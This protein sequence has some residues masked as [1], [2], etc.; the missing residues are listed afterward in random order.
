MTNVLL[1][2]AVGDAL[3]QAFEALRD[4]VHPDLATWDGTMRGGNSFLKLP[5]GSITDDTHFSLAL[6]HS[7]V[8]NGGY[9]F[10]DV[11]QGYAAA[12]EHVGCGSTLRAAVANYRKGKLPQACGI[13][14][15]EHVGSG[16]VMRAAP[17]GVAFHLCSPLMLQSIADDDAR[18][19]HD[20]DEAA[21]GSWI[22]ARMVQLL[23]AG[24]RPK[25][26]IELV[27]SSWNLP[28]AEGGE[29]CPYPRDGRAKSIVLSALWFF[30]RH[31]TNHGLIE[32][33]SYGGDTDTRAAVLGA[34][35]GA[36]AYAEPIRLDWLNTLDRTV[37]EECIALDAE[38][39]YCLRKRS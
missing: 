23:M 18:V 22:I 26:A 39:P 31:G 14:D 13:W 5:A 12:S 16:T 32:A 3:G 27:V 20:H 25:D 35:Y 34:L 6:A 11:M 7:L 36:S 1:Y 2:A 24:I 37:R 29:E 15:M 9:E 33:V 21:E 10:D 38:L 30:L 8:R 17:L 19:T 28:E 4:T